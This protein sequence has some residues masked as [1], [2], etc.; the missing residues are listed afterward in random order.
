MALIRQGIC[1]KDSII[2]KSH[3]FYYQIQQQ[4]FVAERTWCDFVVRGSKK[5]LHPQRVPSNMAW[6]KE[7]LVHLENFFD[8]YILH[9]LAYPSLKFGR[10]RND[11][12]IANQESRVFI[13][14]GFFSNWSC[15]RRISYYDLWCYNL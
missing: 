5:E 11:F 7:K 2:N 4:A 12:W 3:Q 10:D 15:L 13:T 14:T 9:E 8:Q 6:W 1:N